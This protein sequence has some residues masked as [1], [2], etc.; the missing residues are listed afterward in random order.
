[1]IDRRAAILTQRHHRPALSVHEV[2]S[3]FVWDRLPE[4]LTIPPATGLLAPTVK[5]KS[6]AF[7][8]QGLEIHD[9]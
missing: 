1:M 5:G 8:T 9:Q 6:L 2:R 4:T 7:A 3:S